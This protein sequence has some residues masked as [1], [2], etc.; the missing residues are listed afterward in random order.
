ME[1]E[2]LYFQNPANR[3]I[4]DRGDERIYRSKF[5]GIQFELHTPLDFDLDT[6]SLEVGTVPDSR[7]SI[8]INIPG[9]I[10][11]DQTEYL[12]NIPRLTGSL[13]QY[14]WTL[15]NEKLA[16]NESFM[17]SEE[18]TF[19]SMFTSLIYQKQK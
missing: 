18:F 15:I 16:T 4:I 17:T 5:Q 2:L 14:N 6:Y 11:R 13:A 10:V 7:L 8:L 1:E 3:D 12:V 19:S 9:S